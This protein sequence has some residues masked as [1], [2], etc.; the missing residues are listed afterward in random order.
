LESAL[1]H[2]DG[3]SYRNKRHNEQRKKQIFECESEKREKGGKARDLVKVVVRVSGLA[4][5]EEIE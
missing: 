4:V 3:L 5:Q 2:D 1:E